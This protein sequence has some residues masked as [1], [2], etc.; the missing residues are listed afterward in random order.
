MLTIAALRRQGVKSFTST[1]ITPLSG[2][3][4]VL[5]IPT[6]KANATQHD[7]PLRSLSQT[8]LLISVLMSVS[9][10]RYCQLCLQ[11]A[12]PLFC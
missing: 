4:T 3:Q 6:S 1:A 8:L 7:H 2:V 12:M 10:F 11:H 5:C 9:R